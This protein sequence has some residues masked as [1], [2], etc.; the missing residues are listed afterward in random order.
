[1]RAFDLMMLLGSSQLVSALRQTKHSKLTIE[2]DLTKVEYQPDGD[3]FQ[4]APL[5]D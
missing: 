5:D 3:F 4:Q 1:M 2:I